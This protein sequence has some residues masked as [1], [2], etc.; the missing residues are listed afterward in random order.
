MTWNWIDINQGVD[1][2][3]ITAGIGVLIVRQFLWRS[4]QTR[5]MLRIPTLIIAAGIVYL[6]FQLWGGV[7]WRAPDWLIVAELL[8]VAFTGTAMGYVTHFRRV[9][10]QIQYRLT[11][12]GIFL[13]A[14]FIVVR[15]ANFA[16]ADALGANLA[17]ATGLILLSFGINRLAAILVVRRRLVRVREVA[18]VEH[19]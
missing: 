11:K 13:W 18:A 1:D 17:D 5:R 6:I 2:V 7:D 15:I 14:L 4:A 12:I 3:V 16:L 19:S 8:L 10:D 9:G